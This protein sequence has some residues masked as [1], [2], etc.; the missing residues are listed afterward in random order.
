M[1]LSAAGVAFR[2]L[3]RS[4]ALPGLRVRC[5]SE[6]LS[7]GRLKTQGAQLPDRAP[8]LPLPMASASS[9]APLG[10]AFRSWQVHGLI[11]SAFTVFL[12]VTGGEKLSLEVTPKQTIA[13]L[14]AAVATQCEIPAEN[15]RLIYKGQVL[16]DEKTIEDYGKRGFW[17]IAVS[18]LSA[19][20]TLLLRPA[21]D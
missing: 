18:T 15:Q 6:H 8:S 21:S 16:K 1:Y 20:C 19:M 4:R 10:R 11:M 7:Q 13:E 5:P 14:K 9:Q 17:N 3:P 12:K 2:N